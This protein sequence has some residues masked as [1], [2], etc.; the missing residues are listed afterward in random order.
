MLL[1]STDR[2]LL[3]EAADALIFLA[4]RADNLIVDATTILTLG[5]Y[6][7]STVAAPRDEAPVPTQ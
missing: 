7:F 4:S 5:L 1:A 6:H 2:T 3:Q